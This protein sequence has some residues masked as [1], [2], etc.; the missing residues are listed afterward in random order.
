MKEICFLDQYMLRI[1]ISIFWEVVDLFLYPNYVK[2]QVPDPKAQVSSSIFTK[3][4]H[5]ARITFPTTAVK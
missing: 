4:N 5:V 3:K 2:Q 1:S